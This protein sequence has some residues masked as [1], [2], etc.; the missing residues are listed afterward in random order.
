M[1]LSIIRYLLVFGALVLGSSSHG[2]N[3]PLPDI[4]LQPGANHF[5]QVEYRLDQ[6]VHELYFQRVSS[7]WRE[8]FWQPADRAFRIEHLGDRD[9]V[10][11]T[12]GAAFEYLE[13]L[14]PA[15]YRPL[16][17]EYAPFAPFSD[18]GLLIHS[19]QFHACIVAGPC[20]PERP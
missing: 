7:D 20:D 16:P 10:Y 13:I 11:R 4:V 6:S 8:Q 14:V 15:R 5:W 3:N 9:R 12:D 18:G 2:V 17:G 1:R 19:G